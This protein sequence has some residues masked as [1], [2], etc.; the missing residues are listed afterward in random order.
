MKWSLSSGWMNAGW[1][2]PDRVDHRGQDRHR[3]RVRR[4]AVEVMQHVL[5]DEL[6]LAEHAPELR[7][8]GGGRQLAEDQEV[9]GFDEARALGE[10]LDRVAAVAKDAF[11]AVDERDLARARAG[12]GVAAVERDEPGLGAQ[13][14]DV[15]RGL[16]FGADDG[17][18]LVALAV[19]TQRSVLG[20]EGLRLSAR[21]LRCTSRRSVMDRHDRGSRNVARRRPPAPKKHLQSMVSVLYL[22]RFSLRAEGLSSLVTTELPGDEQVKGPVPVDIHLR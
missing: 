10:L 15:D 18:Q 7:E 9:G 17:G 13:L 3:R 6:V 19:V 22:R 20:H 8:L 16:G 14:R 2:Q 12:V 21:I 4:E 1:K 11:F 5:V